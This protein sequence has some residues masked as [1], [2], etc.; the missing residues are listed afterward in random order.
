MQEI[1]LLRLH[2]ETMKYMEIESIFKR[3]TQTFINKIYNLIRD[4][5][6]EEHKFT[7]QVYS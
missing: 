5:F 4:I 7:I 3:L 2:R 1:D 6:A